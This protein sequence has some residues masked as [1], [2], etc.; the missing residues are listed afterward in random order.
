MFPFVSERLL[1]SVGG[2]GA[3][4]GVFEYSDI[5]WEIGVGDGWGI[6]GM[7]QVLYMLGESRRIGVGF[8]SR[9][10]RARLGPGDLPGIKTLENWISFGATLSIHF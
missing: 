4:L 1:I 2:G 7:G 5:N 6:Y 9:G 10:Y 3:Y 8:T